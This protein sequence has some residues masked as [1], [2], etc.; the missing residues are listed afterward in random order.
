MTSLK[1][2]S[3]ETGQL[4]LESNLLALTA[5]NH[6][7]EASDVDTTLDAA[8]EDMEAT[9]VTGVTAVAATEVTV[10]AATGV[11]AD[12]DAG[13]AADGLPWEVTVDTAVAITTVVDTRSGA[14]ITTVVDTR[15]GAAMAT[16]VDTRGGAAMATDMDAVGLLAA[17]TGVTAMEGAVNVNAVTMAINAIHEHDVS[18]KGVD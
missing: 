17:D 8:M 1:A 16:D 6:I 15:S 10:V 11:T 2:F 4:T 5:L 7:T 12:M 3:L 18:R 14:A 13:S 9:G